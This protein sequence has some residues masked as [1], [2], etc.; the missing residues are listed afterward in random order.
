MIDPKQLEGYGEGW[1][2]GGRNDGKTPDFSKF[3]LNKGYTQY[4]QHFG[5]TDPLIGEL[6]GPFWYDYRD[7]ALTVMNELGAVDSWVEYMKD[8]YENDNIDF[9]SVEGCLDFVYDIAENPQEIIGDFLEENGYL[10]E[11]DCLFGITDK[12]YFEELVRN[13]FD[14]DE[15]YYES[16]E[17]NMLSFNYYA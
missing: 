9:N 16:I 7:N 10:H 6:E 13:S 15:T 2:F 8:N 1:A 11:R 14:D 17:D 4:V 3:E 12:D 5:T